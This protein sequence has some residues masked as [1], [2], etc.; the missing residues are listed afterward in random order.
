MMMST[1][2]CMAVMAVLCVGIAPGVA[3]PEAQVVARDLQKLRVPGKVS[4]V[5][6]TRRNDTCTLQV[7]LQMTTE[8]QIRAKVYAQRAAAGVAG[9]PLPTPKLPDVQAWLL[10]QDGAAISRIA[11]TP[12]FPAVIKASDGV[13]LE[14]QY[15]YPLAAAQE[16][17]AVAIMVDGVYFIEQLLP[18]AKHGD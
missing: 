11:G 7:V 17:V 2:L 10:G 16:A 6:W 3:W 5:V 18:L 8:Y 14:M 1:R 9:A 13:P 12:A 15:S 4:A